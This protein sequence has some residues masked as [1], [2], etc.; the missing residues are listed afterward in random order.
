LSVPSSNWTAVTFGCYLTARLQL[1][2][3]LSIRSA[4]SWRALR[5]YYLGSAH[6]REQQDQGPREGH[7]QDLQRH[8]RCHSSGLVRRPERVSVPTVIGNTSLESL[9]RVGSGTHT[10]RG[11]W[12]YGGPDGRRS[13]AKG[14][15]DY[16]G[17]SIHHMARLLDNSLLDLHDTA[18]RLAGSQR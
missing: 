4:A 18:E 9:K 11:P 14:T 13:R 7:G 8:P 17:T 16:S 10:S 3:R 15:K 6:H 2:Q 1:S 5:V 12:A